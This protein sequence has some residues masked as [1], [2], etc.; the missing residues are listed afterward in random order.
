MECKP[1][2]PEDFNDAI[3]RSP[4]MGDDLRQ[5][6]K[7]SDR[8]A[9]FV[10]GHLMIPRVLKYFANMR[11]T[12]KVDMVYATLPLHKL[13]HF[14]DKGEAGLP[15]IMESSSPSDVVEGMLVFG[16][17]S[18]QRNVVK[19]NE[20]GRLEQ[21]V[22]AAVQ[23]QVSQMDKISFFD[24]KCE[25]SVDA[26]TF[27]WNSNENGLTPMGSSFWPIDDFLE[28]R[29]YEGIVEYQKLERLRDDD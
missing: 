19:E 8:P 12:E 25:K 7:S 18:E 20:L 13:Y 2:Y 21:M 23:V 26:G 4:L 3:K 5:L 16:L 11:E 22:F 9:I 15:T 24:V 17:T 14:S 27:V 10:Y 6:I 28:H 29:L 1:E